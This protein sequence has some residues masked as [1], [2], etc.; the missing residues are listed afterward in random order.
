MHLIFKEAYGK[1]F[2][3]ISGYGISVDIISSART[4]LV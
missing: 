2:L 3:V 1:S 4:L